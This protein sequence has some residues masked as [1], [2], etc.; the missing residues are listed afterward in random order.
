M[1]YE[2]SDGVPLAK[3]D[4][5]YRGGSVQRADSASTTRSYSLNDEQK[6]RSNSNPPAPRYVPSLATTPATPAALDHQQDPY[7]DAYNQHN[8][9]NPQHQHQPRASLDREASGRRSHDRTPSIRSNTA[10]PH[11]YGNPD[12]A[13]RA[14]QSHGSL[15]QQQQHL[16]P[17][18]QTN[19]HS[20]L[21]TVREEDSDDY[22]SE[23]DSE[24]EVYKIKDVMEDLKTQNIS[25]GLFSEKNSGDGS[26]DEP[27]KRRRGLRHYSRREKKKGKESNFIVFMRKSFISLIRLSLYTRC[28][29]YWLPLALILFIPLAIGAWGNKN[30]TLGQAKLMWIF[31]W[32]EIVWGSL[33]VSRLIAHSLPYVYKTLCSIIMPKMRKYRSVFEAME[34]PISLVFW[35]LI[36]LCTFMPVMTQKANADAKDATQEW[37]RVINNILVA[38]LITALLYF[39]EVLMVHL[40]SVSFHKTRFAMRIRDNKQAIRMLSDLLYV[41]CIP[42]PPFC[43][44][45]AEEDLKLQSGTLF[46]NNKTMLGKK[47]ASSHNMQRLFG[48]INKAANTAAAT[49]GKVARG[50]A[51]END[52]VKTWV[53]ATI[54]DSMNSKYLAGI[55]ANRI[56]MSLVLEDSDSLVIDDLVEV[57]GEDRREECQAIFRVLD[58]D[59]NGNLTLDE[60]VASCKDICHERKSV[61]NSLKDVDTAIAKLHSVLL[62]VVLI[63]AVIIFIG[64]LAPSASAVLATLGT[65]ILGFSFVFS[66]TCQEILASCVFLFVKHPLDVGD[67]VDIA[68]DN[69]YVKEISLL[70]TVFT[71]IG[72]GAIVQAPNSVLN[73]V[74]IDNLSRAGPQTFG[75]TFSLGLPETTYDQ[76]EEFKYKIEQFCLENSRDYQ[77]NPFV[78]CTAL[79]DLDRVS[80]TVAVTFRSNFSDGGVYSARRNRLIYQIGH[81]I[82]EVGLSVPR[83]EDSPSDPGLPLNIKTSP[84]FDKAADM[85]SSAVKESEQGENGETIGENGEKAGTQDRSQQALFPR[86]RALMGFGP[87]RNLLDVNDEGLAPNDDDLYKNDSDS[88]QQEGIFIGGNAS[89]HKPSGTI[90]SRG[91]YTQGTGA[92]GLSRRITTGRRRR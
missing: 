50:Q 73:T 83:R 67:R 72:D 22:D 48:R 71:R 91:G 30:A 69:F 53:S 79:P 24:E 56:W 65:T 81:I 8:N 3:I 2:G 20:R 11:A 46:N 13:L 89:V 28:F 23:D 37:Q 55:L 15:Q 6:S 38:L 39:A 36:S 27:H 34:L 70:Y 41:A 86:P 1:S 5:G 25:E 63:I 19:S 26:G 62:F 33:W 85:F 87:N 54:A 12:P 52:D 16:Q 75:L 58:T 31:V 44:E 60:M 42:F 17:I 29:F 4:S 88:T 59:G 84:H 82:H 45:F 68:G 51:L 49:L 76:L 47:I 9:L 35:G 7:A 78:S 74:W 14:M 90:K 18:E 43:P 66:V 40:I 32:L 61:Y 77:E 57:L 92:S 64:M 80:F 21:N 10:G